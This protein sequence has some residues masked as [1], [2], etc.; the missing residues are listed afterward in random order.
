MK[1]NYELTLEQSQKLIMTPELRQAIQ[2]LQYN[3]LEL[4]EYILREI[5]ENP[6]LEYEDT[7][8]EP[9]EISDFDQID[10]KEYIENYDD[11]SY[12][13]EINKDE[14][15]ITFEN[16]FT[17]SQTLKEYLLEQLSMV[18]VGQREYK[19]AEYIIQNIDSNGYLTESTQEI[20]KAM[21]VS[22]SEVEIMLGV[23]QTF[24]PTGVGARNLKECLLLQLKDRKDLI[25]INI[26]ENYLEDIAL[27]KLSKI[28]SELNI[29]VEEVQRYA[30]EIKSLEPK[31]GRSFAGSS[32]EIKYIIPDAKLE[33]VDGE[34]VVLINE[35]T[36]PK[37]NIN[38]FY[39]ELIKNSDETTSQFL[40]EKLN[41]AV[42][43]IKSI[44]QRKQTLTK[45]IESIVK[46]QIDFFEKGEG[47]LKPLTLKDVA[48]DIKMHEST[49]SRATNGKYIQTSK[50]IYE[51]KYFFSQ[52]IK[53]NEGLISSDTVKNTIREIIDSEDSKKPMSDQEISYKL[54]KMGIS[55]SR[56]TVAKYREELKIPS[57]KLRKRF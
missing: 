18:S 55:L 19:I 12:K 9:Q 5:E 34:Y 16:F 37:L 15:T 22:E 4:Q 41:S 56:R 2:L 26:V 24:E 35:V 46:F 23:V 14:N 25:L 3:S 7:I 29:D 31:P 42:W 13:Q 10:W 6:L 1:L 40:Q 27:N 39:R 38:N 8:E 28:A 44:E 30:D 48:E 49:V 43:I 45:V 50:G 51:L 53:A 47:Y 36:I 11:I 20:A 57:S 54:E 32:E 17:S 52:A 33:K 21:G